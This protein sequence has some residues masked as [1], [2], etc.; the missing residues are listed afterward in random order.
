MIGMRPI[1]VI[2]LVCVFLALYVFVLWRLVSKTG[3]P[4]GL[5]LLLLVPLVNLAFVI[6]L[7]F[8]EWPIQREL[9]RL[10]MPIV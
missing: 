6:Y 1:E 10:K 9:R 8:S 3:H 2:L 5:S 7:A 4:G